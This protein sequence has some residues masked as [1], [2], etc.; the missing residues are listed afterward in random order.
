MAY[1]TID[2]PSA[3]FQT[4]LYNG[5]SGTQSV[6]NDG[7][8]D[9]QPDMVW[10]KARSGTHG[11]ENHNLY[12]SVRGA[13]KFFIPNGTTTSSTD[14]NSLTAFNTDGFSLG[15][16]TDVNGSGAYVGWNWKAGGSAS[17]N[18]NG[19]ITSTV[20]ANQT[21]GF[22]IVSFT[23]NGSAGATVGHGLSAIPKFILVKVHTSS[24]AYDWRVFH[25]SLGATTESIELTDIEIETSIKVAELVKG[26]IVGVDLLP[27]KN[28]EKEKPYVLEANATPGFGGIERITKDKSITQEILKTYFNRDK[29]RL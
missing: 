23:G 2:D 1:T 8:S 10:I 15:T 25:A 11:T 5:N 28:R 21:A 18:S 12:D 27:A 19:S 14:T 17:S 24:T 20:S 6:V 29:W 16:R 9:L 26:D 7:N 4:A 22:S 13:N 3:Y